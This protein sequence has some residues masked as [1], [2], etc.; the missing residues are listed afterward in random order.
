MSEKDGIDETTGKVDVYRLCPNPGDSIMVVN[1]GDHF[2]LRHHSWSVNEEPP[3]FLTELDI[4]LL[5]Q[6]LI[7]WN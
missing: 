5:K 4:E 2:E 1:C 3:I 7:T 6:G